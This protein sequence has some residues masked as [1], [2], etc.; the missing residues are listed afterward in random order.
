MMALSAIPL[1]VIKDP[2]PELWRRCNGSCMVVRSL[3]SQPGAE[4]PL[5]LPFRNA[6]TEICGTEFLIGYYNGATTALL[7]DD[8]EPN[9]NGVLDPAL[10]LVAG[11]FRKSIELGKIAKIEY[12]PK[13][14]SIEPTE[15]HYYRAIKAL[16]RDMVE[17]L[18]TSGVRMLESSHSVDVIA[19][20]VSKLALVSHCQEFTRE[21]DK[22]PL[23]LCIG[24]KGAWPGNDY[25]LLSTPYSLSV[26][27][28]SPDPD[29][30]WNVSPP[31]ERG[32][33]ATLGY[34]ASI[35]TSRLGLRIKLRK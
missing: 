16:V 31:G 5:G 25:Y 20:D 21:V 9:I 13:Q 17:K 11:S 19:P 6:F 34:L 3:G 29:S 18:G 10:E 14:I 2:T 33:Q 1:S 7:G 26:D 8:E 27:T 4:D 35:E 32:V 28:V 30:C 15:T 23:V 12:R 24:D 22:S